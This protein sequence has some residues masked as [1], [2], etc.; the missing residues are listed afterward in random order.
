MHRPRRVDVVTDDEGSL[1]LQQPL[2]D[3]GCLGDD[4]GPGGLGRL[5]VARVD[6]DVVPHGQG[7][8]SGRAAGDVDEPL[9]GG[10]TRQVDGHH[11]RAP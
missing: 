1:D 7:E 5:R 11:V 9:P 2:G 6:A 10:P 4:V 8:A 3:L